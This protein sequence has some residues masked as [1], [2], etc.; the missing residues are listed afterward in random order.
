[1]TTSP[2]L[3]VAPDPVE[4]CRMCDWRGRCRDQ[5]V[6]ADH[7]SLVAGIR[8]DQRRAL[9]RAG[10]STLDGL[11]TLPLSPPPE[12]LRPHA[13]ERIPEQARVQLAVRSAGAPVHEI[14]P[15]EANPGG[16]PLRLA[17]LP[18]PTPHDWFFDFEGADYAYDQGLE[19]LWGI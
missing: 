17:A 19:Y 8:A 14:L 10:V 2:E 9:E 18:E 15:L 6:E 1:P 12:G 16:P 11:A 13:S 5:R 4:L 3:P 7:L